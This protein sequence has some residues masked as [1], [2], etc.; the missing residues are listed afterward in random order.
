MLKYSMNKYNKYQ[1]KIS[2]LAMAGAA[3]VLQNVATAAAIRSGKLGG[4][5]GH[6]LVEGYNGAKITKMDKLK[7]GALSLVSPESAILKTKAR[8]LGEW[9][10]SKTRQIGAPVTP[11][12]M[13]VAKHIVNG[14]FGKAVIRA[15]QTPRLVQLTNQYAKE[16]G[17]VVH[18]HSFEKTLRMLS[19]PEVK[20]E[21]V[22]KHNPITS[23]VLPKA[24]DTIRKRPKEIHA[25][26]YLQNE[27]R[28]AIA[29]NVGVMAADPITGVINLGKTLMVHPKA[30]QNKYLHKIIKKVEDHVVVS[31]VKTSFSQGVKGT[32]PKSSLKEKA[33]RIANTYG[34][35]AMAS[36]LKNTSGNL[37]NAVRS[38][39]KRNP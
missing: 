39:L 15:K 4:T 21:W 16:K 37:G 32:L 19:S 27:H 35:N 1:E 29:A 18:P 12:E 5:L 3:H 34:V 31:P 36:E 2:S 11:R 23:K 9:I 24:F 25:G 26:G 6:H 20:K 33:T 13:V 22:D 7:Q 8:G 28:P 10:S 17:M 14:D 38:S 30:Q